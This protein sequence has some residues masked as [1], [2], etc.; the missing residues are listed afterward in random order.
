MTEPQFKIHIHVE[1]CD[2]PGQHTETHQDLGS[3]RV[4]THNSAATAWTDVLEIL[5]RH[6]GPSPDEPQRS[7]IEQAKTEIEYSSTPRCQDCKKPIPGAT[8]TTHGA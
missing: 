2:N 8:M 7:R 5:I 3:I 4:G 1:Q 6:F